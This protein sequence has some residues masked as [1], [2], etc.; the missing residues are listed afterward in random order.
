MEVREASVQ[1]MVCMACEERGTSDGVEIAES[2]LLRVER[3]KGYGSV[4]GLDDEELADSAELERQVVL[5]E[6]GPILALPFKA[7]GG[8][9]PVIDEFGHMDFGAFGTWD[10]ERLHGAFDKARYKAAK[11]RERRMHDRIMLDMV[12]ERVSPELRGLVRS[13]A[14]NPVVELEH[15][16]DPNARAYAKWLRRIRCL[17]AQIREIRANS[18]GGSAGEQD[19]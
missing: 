19:A 13:L 8:I 2:P 10:F 11:L 3:D 4:P 12:R 16:I 14:M 17:A 5:A 1:E 9:R 15:I 18:Q 6:W 7:Y